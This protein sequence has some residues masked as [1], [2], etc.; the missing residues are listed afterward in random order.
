MTDGRDSAPPDEPARH[1]EECQAQVTHFSGA[2]FKKFNTLQEANA[3]L[4]GSSGP[5]SAPEMRPSGTYQASNTWAVSPTPPASWT[6]APAPPAAPRTAP[7]AA[8]ASGR[9]G[10]YGSGAQGSWRPMAG[11]AA[12]AP[13]PAAT[14]VQPEVT[15]YFAGTS[16]LGK[17]KHPAVRRRPGACT[18]SCRLDAL[19]EATR[20][21]AR[22]SPQDEEARTVVYT[23][24]CAF[25]NGAATA[26]AGIGVYWGPNDR[27]YDGQARRGPL[28]AAARLLTDASRQISGAA[29]AAS[30]VSE[31]VQGLAT[32]QRAE[33]GVRLGRVRS[34]AA[35][36]PSSGALAYPGGGIGAAQAAL[37]ALAD[38]RDEA[39][40]L[41]IRTDSKYTING[42]TR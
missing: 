40:P 33:L 20:A 3:F 6:A 4:H 31:P 23:D 15:R 19:T 26:R 32:N 39:T 27:R 7:P 12:A 34:T 36:N 16:T 24:G 1:R 41:E 42:T 17:R 21:G 35:T 29:V 13:R 18:R 10:S 28:S 38:T 37:R 8:A 25:S 22:A 5:A 11:R 14:T 2:V 9:G 30:N